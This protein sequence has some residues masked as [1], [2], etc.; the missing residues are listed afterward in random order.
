M[1]SLVETDESVVVAATSSNNDMKVELVWRER[2]P[3][4]MNLL[5]NDDSGVLKVVDF[6]RGSQARLVAERRGFDPELFK[7]ASIVAVNGF[8]YTDQEELFDALKDPSRPKTVE[9]QLAESED[10][11][12][13]RRFLERGQS[14]TVSP[15]R[16]PRTFSFRRVLFHEPGELGIEFGSTLDNVGLEVRRFVE[17]AGG[18]IL[19]AERS[20]QI[21][22]GDLLTHV[23]DIPAISAD[24]SVRASAI[25]LLESV[26]NIRPLALSFISPHLH[27]VKIMKPV[28]DAS[29]ISNGDPNELI[30]DEIKDANG[31][32]RI[33][34]VA[35][36]DVSG[37][38]ESSGVLI[39]DH[40]VFINGLPV[41]AGCRWLGTP[42]AP[43]ID[44]V[45]HMLSN[46]SFYPVGLTFARPRKQQGSRW[47]GQS[48]NFTDSEADTFCVTSD[49]QGQIG[50]I[51]EQVNRTDIVVTDF[52]AVAGVFQSSLAHCK[53]ATGEICLTIEAING[54]F[55][56]SYASAEMVKNALVRSW[57]SDA[58]V[59]L[60]LC[61]D[62]LKNW[63]FSNISSPD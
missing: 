51:L 30:L 6:P 62:T 59:D 29:I 57:K 23:N 4:G 45:V 40:L 15:S 17:G 56:P 8:E 12:R 38:A 20:G 48:E 42:S 26:A 1:D 10:L 46:E 2:L 5:M 32:K 47:I 27:F 35:F 60:M 11:E 39:G 16:T 50:C 25:E 44:E 36:R 58:S 3:L 22:I 52:L 54:Q 33:R 19:A 53:D 28:E 37:R 13:L 7:G 31:R 61:D 43:S 55:V 41:G 34:V 24:G 49:T 18:V 14:Q 63:L 9:F 21:K